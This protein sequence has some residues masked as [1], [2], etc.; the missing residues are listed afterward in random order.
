MMI[1]NNH[2]IIDIEYSECHRFDVLE[3]YQDTENKWR[4]NITVSRGGAAE[5]IKVLRGFVDEKT[6]ESDPS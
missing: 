1:I 4:H 6:K 2:E 5:L 3:L